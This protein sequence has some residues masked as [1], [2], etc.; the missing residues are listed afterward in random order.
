MS[1]TY[2]PTLR[3]DLDWVRLLAGDR[4]VTN[5]TVSDEEILA[6]LDEEPNKYFAA[7]V[8]CDLI[9]TKTG[10]IIDK[11]VGDLR[12][13]WNDSPKSAYQEYIMY[14]RQRGAYE[15]GKDNYVFKV[16]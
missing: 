16:L 2:D 4:D 14:L 5:Y 8:I 9:L 3:S 12:I 1:V 13:K 6:A 15:L 7:A 10:G 11:Q